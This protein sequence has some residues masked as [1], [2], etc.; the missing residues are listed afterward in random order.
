MIAKVQWMPSVTSILCYPTFHV[1]HPIQNIAGFDG[2]LP[3]A[4]K[5]LSNTDPTG[6]RRFLEEIDLMK[7]FCHPNIISLLGEGN[8]NTALHFHGSCICHEIMSYMCDYLV[9]GWGQC[10]CEL[11]R[12]AWITFDDFGVYAVW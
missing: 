2:S 12:R 9:G 10:R 8:F 1:L 6:S 11:S 3:V 4:V 5:T 7:T